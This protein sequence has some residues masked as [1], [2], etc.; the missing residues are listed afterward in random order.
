MTRTDKVFNGL[1]GSVFLD[2]AKKVADRI[3]IDDT[4]IAVAVNAFP[5]DEDDN[6][7]PYI[8]TTIYGNDCELSKERE[9]QKK[10]R[11]FHLSLDIIHTLTLHVFLF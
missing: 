10:S 9:E 7:A 6:P 1:A 3:G 8:A 4:A 5:E 2:V 11:T